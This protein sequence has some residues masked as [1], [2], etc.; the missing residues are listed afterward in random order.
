MHFQNSQTFRRGV[1][2]RYTKIL[3]V[4]W[5]RFEAFIAQAYRKLF[6]ETKTSQ[7]KK[8]DNL[9]K[10]SSLL[11]NQKY[12]DDGDSFKKR[13]VLNLSDK[14]LEPA[15]DSLLKCGLNHFTKNTA[16]R[17]RSS[18]HGGGM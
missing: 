18:C 17:R 4:D 16:S 15:V 13:R 3:E 14:K 10:K 11:D 2:R 6:N 9:Q 12:N 7:R 5:P 8:Y 1:I